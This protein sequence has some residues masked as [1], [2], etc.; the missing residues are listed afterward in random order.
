MFTGIVEES[1]KIRGIRKTKSGIRLTVG[2]KRTNKDFALGSS[3]AVDGVCLTVIQKKKKDLSF[4]VS[5]NTLRYTT[6]GLRKPGETV[7]LERPLKFGSRLGGHLVQ[8][9]VD[10]VGII[11][12]RRKEGKNL[13]FDIQ[14]SRDLLA[15]MVLRGSVTVDGVSLT[16][17]GLSKKTFG[18]YLIP[19]T[20]RVTGLHK[21]QAGDKVNIEVDLLMKLL[22]Q[23]MK[24]NPFMKKLSWLKHLPKLKRLP[25]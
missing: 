25:A 13:I 7:N 6:L 4:D 19:H 21:K 5:T 18:L 20:L 11:K 22:F 2:T 14:C 24:R 23:R 17:T 15:Y 8:G 3:I 9:H 10:G 12:S 16:I 1:G